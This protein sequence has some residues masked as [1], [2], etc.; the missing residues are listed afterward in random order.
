MQKTNTHSIL[1]QLSRTDFL[2]LEAIE[3]FQRTH[4]IAYPGRRWL[5]RHCGVNC[6]TVSRHI[7]RLKRLGLIR[8]TYRRYRRKNGTWNTRSNIYELLGVVGAKVRGLI[9]SIRAG[10]RRSTLT[11]NKEKKEGLPDL[12]FV[13]DPA[14]R[15]ALERFSKLGGEAA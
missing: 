14:R 1:L 8:V 2:I 12:S 7:S 10:V 6:W 9:Q 15:A 3:Y 5:A 13:K 11:Q 4:G